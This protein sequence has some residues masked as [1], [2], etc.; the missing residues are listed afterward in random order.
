MQKSEDELKKSRAVVQDKALNDYVREV[1]CRVAGDH[2]ADIRL[3]IVH[4]PYFNASMAPN[5]MMQV[6]TG[7]LLRSQN[8][9]QLAAVLGHEIGHYLER[10]SLQRWRDIRTKT[11][12]MAFA[13]LGLGA[14]GLGSVANVGQIAMLASIM[15][16]SRDNEREA[17]EIGLDLMTRAGY[18]P[19]EAS[20]V[21]E[22]IVAE[23]AA[24]K[25][26]K[27]GLGELF[28]GS[29]PASEERAETLRAKA[30][31]RPGEAYSVRYRDKVAGIRRMLLEDEL[32]LR[33]YDRTL[34]V[35]KGIAAEKED[36]EVAF[37]TGEV[38][39]LR[40]GN[41][42]R[43]EARKTLER[44]LEFADCPA[45][46]DRSLGLIHRRDGSQEAAAASFRRYLER[47]PDA[48]DRA[49]IMSYIG[50]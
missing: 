36:G 2:C 16:F 30:V 12:I 24:D 46:A 6:W 39:R 22:Q 29:H 15:S 18:A 43:E 5:G 40:D 4:T 23:K 26:K 31:G 1:M 37:Y 21:W 48:S 7:L 38:H 25:D 34:V 49:M 44:A 17:D 33:Q 14:A 41:G 28:F 19:I 35:L 32:K 27:D 11:D 13:G 42:D 20:K 10:H 50:S 45:E 3:Y 47:R 9:A 8:E